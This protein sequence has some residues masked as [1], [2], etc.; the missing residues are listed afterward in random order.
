MKKKYKKINLSMHIKV[1]V[2]DKYEDYF[3]KKLKLINKYS[4]I[5]K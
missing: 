4:M 3:V 2:F 5:I 1:S